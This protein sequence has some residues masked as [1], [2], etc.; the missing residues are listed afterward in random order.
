MDM[1]QLQKELATKAQALDCMMTEL[2]SP[3]RVVPHAVKV[4]MN[5]GWSLDLTTLDPFTGRKW[6]LAD[7]KQQKRVLSM[8]GSHKPY[9]VNLSP[10]CTKF[11]K[12]QNMNPRRFH[13]SGYAI[14][15][16]RRP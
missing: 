1:N 13:S 4:G 16:R 2:F 8:I 11:S 5:M 12:L 3:P 6:D 9:F 14:W 15:R 10:P 7:P